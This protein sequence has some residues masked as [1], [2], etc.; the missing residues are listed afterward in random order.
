MIDKKYT[1]KLDHD[2]QYRRSC[3]ILVRRKPDSLMVGLLSLVQSDQNIRTPPIER[4]VMSRSKK[5]VST[6]HAIYRGMS[7]IRGNSTYLLVHN[8]TESHHSDL[9]QFKRLVMARLICSS[10]ETHLTYAG[11]VTHKSIIQK[12]HYKLPYVNWS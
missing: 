3:F 8:S 10:L 5:V 11:F 1:S 6:Y 7:I 2:H 9:A 12:F 4:T